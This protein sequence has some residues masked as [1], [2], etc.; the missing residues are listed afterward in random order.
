MKGGEILFSQDKKLTDRTVKKEDRMKATIFY[1]SGTGNTWFVAETLKR[2]LQYRSIDAEAFSIEDTTLAEEGKL[3]QLIAESEHILIGYPIYGSVAPKPMIDFIENLPKTY[4]GT[5][6]SVFSTVALASGDGP[7]VYREIFEAR[8][9]RF[10]TG[11][12]FKLSNNFNVPGFPDVLHVGNEENIDRRND[13]ARIKVEKMADSVAEGKTMVEGDHFLGRLLGNL[14]RRHIDE[15]LVKF[16]DKLYVEN[17]KC[18]G[19]EKCIQI[20]PV[21]NISEVDGEIA[22]KGSCAVCMRCYHFCSAKAINV[23]KASLDEKKWPRF[24]GATKAYQEELLKMK[25]KDS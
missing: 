6:M 3:H 2:E 7:V 16:N 23:T 24:R 8:G 12:E 22:F 17:S 9:Y 19:C 13:K 14:Q 25:T 4:K 21:N 5:M 15:L 11:M 20:C 1:F 10:H 18:I